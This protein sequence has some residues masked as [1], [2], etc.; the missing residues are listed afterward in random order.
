[1]R[2]ILVIHG[3]EAKPILPELSR[4]LP[5]VAFISLDLDLLTKQQQDTKDY[6]TDIDICLLL[7]S[8]ALFDL[9][10]HREMPRDLVAAIRALRVYQLALTQLT[11]EA[12]T[13]FRNLFEPT[14]VF[15]EPSPPIL[16]LGLE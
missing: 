12:R 16:E 8:D 1:M 11:E 5:E 6:F 7:A 4:A 10:M 14:Y 15:P 3:P 2:R 9:L 13:E